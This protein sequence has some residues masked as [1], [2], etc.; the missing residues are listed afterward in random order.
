MSRRRNPNI[1]RSVQI[2]PAAAPNVQASFTSISNQLERFSSGLESTIKTIELPFVKEAGARFGADLNRPITRFQLNSLDAAFR[3]SAQNAQRQ[4]LSASMQ[5][6]IND[7]FEGLLRSHLLPHNFN[8]NSVED[9]GKDAAETSIEAIKNAPESLK[10]QTKNLSEFHTEQGLNIVGQRVGH[11]NHNILQQSVVE[12][13]DSNQV[14]VDS[15]FSKGEVVDVDGKPVEK[16]SIFLGQ[17]QQKIDVAIQSRTISPAQGAIMLHQAEQQGMESF[18]LGQFERQFRPN[19]DP[20]AFIQKF[21][22]KPPSGLSPSQI[23]KLASRMN[24]FYG[25]MM[26]LQRANL[27]T[28]QDQGKNLIETARFGADNDDSARNHEARL[29][30]IDPIAAQQFRQKYDVA[31]EEAEVTG[32]MAV[33][34]FEQT[35]REIEKLRV[36][37]ND[38]RF[39]EK[40]KLVE[41]LLSKADSLKTQYDHDKSAYIKKYMPAVSM[42]AHE[43]SLTSKG[44]DDP[45]FS[46]PLSTSV[47]DQDHLTYQI[48]FNR[49][50]P[51]GEIQILGPTQA[52]SFIKNIQG[53]SVE[54]QKKSVDQ[55][56]I[57]H[58]LEYQHI[59]LGELNAKGLDSGLSF[60]YRMANNPNGQPFAFDVGASQQIPEAEM[61]KDISANIPNSSQELKDFR[62][63]LT[64][65]SDYQTWFNTMTQFNGL[66]EADIPNA[67]APIRKYGLYLML[68]KGMNGDQAAKAAV[69]NMIN[70]MT[71]YGVFNGINYQIPK[72]F[73]INGE[74]QRVDPDQINNTLNL[75]MGVVL[76]SFATGNVVIPQGK[77]ILPAFEQES[78]GQ[79]VANN[80]T[81][82]ESQSVIKRLTD[83]I[84]NRSG[85]DQ[86]S[87]NGKWA[88]SPDGKSYFLLWGSGEKVQR[89][90]EGH[91]EDVSIPVQDIIT[92]GEVT[93]HW[94]ESSSNILTGIQSDIGSMNPLIFSRAS[95]DLSI[96]SKFLQQ[97]GIDPITQKET[98]GTSL[99]SILRKTGLVSLGELERQAE[100]REAETKE[101]TP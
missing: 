6:G 36:P 57:K 58:P 3:Q 4:A 49:G 81:G 8:A 19:G 26:H 71:D 35:V 77:R 50:T 41:S 60:Q 7:E 14:N 90:V 69:D 98:P 66:K 37:T 68:T 87:V 47:K 67:T 9:Y 51:Q 34:G 24:S 29:A 74:W 18:Y 65:N 83:Q 1:G 96:V 15:A 55:E 22:Q 53:L 95:R 62:N 20:A 93:Q 42:S 59:V 38:P 40:E 63:T 91:V 39:G 25:S 45:T 2:Q 97:A 82:K 99:E 84:F 28:L 94:K 13:T 16:G 75:G 76:G 48:Q 78:L 70:S 30:E 89:R 23:I 100:R 56:L 5:M 73:S 21:V 43:N 27:G 46:S 32:Q 61:T 54:D 72:Q 12:Y 101:T 33:T 52:S 11:L 64:S 44:I 86:L 92:N 85:Q 80:I 17:L 88:L 10:E 31:H 79:L